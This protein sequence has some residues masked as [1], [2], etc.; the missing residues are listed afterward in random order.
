MTTLFPYGVAI[1]VFYGIKKQI[2][3]GIS[4]ARRGLMCAPPAAADY[5]APIRKRPAVC[6]FATN[7]LGDAWEATSKVQ[8]LRLAQDRP[9]AGSGTGVRTA[10]G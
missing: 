2:K 5:S 6:H 8:A 3:S 7:G 9:W 10:T 4:P 1:A